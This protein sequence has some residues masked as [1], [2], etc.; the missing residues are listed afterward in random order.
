MTKVLIVA[1]VMA[2]A[3]VPAWAGGNGSLTGSYVEARTAEVFTGGC[4]MAS[5]AETMGK[6]AILAWHID[7]GSYEGVALDGL[8]VVAVV[9]GD[10]NLGIHEMGGDRPTL[11]K[12]LLVLDD[13]ANERQ[14]MAL[15]QFARTMAKGLVTDLARLESAP[16][17]FAADPTS[18]QLSAGD[19]KLSVSKTI[20]HGPAC[21]AM[22]WF[23]PL[24]TVK[25]AALGT[26]DQ[27][28]YTG[29]ALGTTWSEPGKR[30]AF[31]APFS[32]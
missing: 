21:G 8:T 3:T 25:E 4:I 6:Q 28:Q 5:E 1:T 31:F 27:H 2:M 20:E 10:R 19:A 23:H 12:S 30:S 9:A 22:Q 24:S 17:H 13:R 7:R 18:I 16:I 11:I 29:S 15:A 26:A 32:F 14:R